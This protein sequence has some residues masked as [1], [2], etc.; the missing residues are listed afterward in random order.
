MGKSLIATYDSLDQHYIGFIYVGQWIRDFF[1]S[2]FLNGHVDFKMWEPAI[3]Y[4]GDVFATMV[5]YFCDPFYWLSVFVAPEF[6]EIA[7]EAIIIFKIYLCGLTFSIYSLKR[8]NSENAVLV[9]VLVYAFAGSVYVGLLQTI[10]LSAMYLFPLVMLGT[11]MLWEE[12]RWGLYVFSLFLTF[13]TYFYFAYMVCIFV[14]G[15]CII[16]LFTDDSFTK[17]AKEVFTRIFDFV[18]SSVLALGTSCVFILPAIIQLAGAGRLGTEYFIP[19]LYDKTRYINYF[20]RFFNSQWAGPDSYVG[21]CAIAAPCLIALFMRKGNMTLK[22]SLIVLML[23]LIFPRFGWMMN[24]FGYVTNRWSFAYSFCLAY[25]VVVMMPQ[26]RTIFANIKIIPILLGCNYI[27]IVVGLLENRSFETLVILCMVFAACLL[28]AFSSAISEKIFWSAAIIITVISLSLT[29]MFFLRLKYGSWLGHELACGEAFSLIENSSALNILSDEQRRQNV[30]Y[31][32]E[33][34]GYVKNASWY[35]GIGGMDFYV[36]IYNNNVDSFHNDIVLLTDP[37][38]YGYEGLNKRSE[39]ESLF[40]VEYYIVNANERYRLPYGYENKVAEGDVNGVTYAAYSPKNKTS[41]M[42]LFDNCISEDYYNTLAPIQKQQA[43]MQ[44]V[45]KKGVGAG[46]EKTAELSFEEQN[47]PYEIVESQGVYISDGMIHVDSPMSYITL[48]IPECSD[49]EIYASFSNLRYENGGNSEY[50]INVRGLDGE[51]EVEGLYMQMKGLNNKS[52]MYGGKNN[53]L[54]NLGH[55]EETIDRIK[56]TFENAGIYTYDNLL[57]YTRS[58][59]SIMR[60]IES[61]NPVGGDIAITSNTICAEV[62][63]KHDSNILL[64]VPYST[65]WTCYIDGVKSD[66]F[67]ADNAF[68]GIPITS[69]VHKVTLQYMTPGLI[70]GL[71]ISLLAVAAI[72][73]MQIANAKLNQKGVIISK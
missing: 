12:R 24:G 30:R 11:C 57:I 34:V 10:F 1:H 54:L 59:E 50:N 62:E 72:V 26:L 9:G 52:H 51:R 19:F 28:A 2:L 13:M 5:V 56:V 16:R 14:F 25:V 67:M 43:L 39:L 38:A 32:K 65:G 64:T 36:S 68:I 4:G 27:L 37:W 33:G 53:W 29:G 61:L 71:F 45:F 6:S 69:G 18:I 49:N 23:G 21:I 3:G 42:Y 55:S 17:T 7:F 60:N 41:L 63:A 66:M 22:I 48:E 15:Y 70:P 35:H 44:A 40:G 58:E 46:S 73:I 31:D 8:G 47:L 20:V